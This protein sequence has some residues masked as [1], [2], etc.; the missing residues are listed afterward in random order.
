MAE[1][2]KTSGEK[3]QLSKA[4][5]VV[6]ELAPTAHVTAL[7][8]RAK[9]SSDLRRSA[10]KG[11]TI[12]LLKDSTDLGQDGIDILPMDED[13]ELY[14]AI[15]ESKRYA[16]KEESQRQ[17]LIASAH[18]SKQ[19]SK[20]HLPTIYRDYTASTK[21]MGTKSG[22]NLPLSPSVC[23]TTDRKNSIQ[24]V[25]LTDKDKEQKELKVAYTAP[26]PQTVTMATGIPIKRKLNSIVDDHECDPE[27]IPETQW[28]TG[29]DD[30]R[31]YTEGVG[32]K[33]GCVPR[34]TGAIKN[35]CLDVGEK[36][37]EKK[38]EQWVNTNMGIQEGKGKNKSKRQ[39]KENDSDQDFQDVS[40]PKRRMKAVANQKER[41]P[42][43]MDETKFSDESTKWMKGEDSKTTN[44]QESSPVNEE[45]IFERKYPA[46]IG[47]Q[48]F[49]QYST[50]E[51]IL[52]HLSALDGTSEWNK[53]PY[54]EG[55]GLTEDS[56]NMLAPTNIW[57]INANDYYSMNVSSYSHQLDPP[58]STTDRSQSV[59]CLDGYHA[60]LT[61]TP[62]DDEIEHSENQSLLPLGNSS[63]ILYN[64]PT[65]S[66]GNEVREVSRNR[67]DE[68]GKNNK[69]DSIKH[70][71]KQPGLVVGC[72][73]SEREELQ[74]GEKEKGTAM[75][76]SQSEGQV[77]ND[78]VGLVEDHYNECVDKEGSVAVERNKLEFRY[79]IGDDNRAKDGVKIDTHI[80]LDQHTAPTDT[81]IEIDSK[82]I[83]GRYQRLNELELRSGPDLN[84]TEKH[85][86]KAGYVH[87][88]KDNNEKE[89]EKEL[90]YRARDSRDNYVIS[91]E[92][93][94]KSSLATKLKWVDRFNSLDK[95]DKTEI[96]VKDHPRH[97]YNPNG[98]SIN[99]SP[100]DDLCFT[101]SEGEEKAQ[102]GPGKKS[103]F[104]HPKDP[105]S[106][107]LPTAN[108]RRV[109][110]NLNEKY[111]THNN[112][113]PKGPELDNNIDNPLDSIEMTDVR[114]NG[115]EIN[116]SDKLVEC[117][118][119]KKSV[120][121]EVLDQHESHCYGPVIESDE[122]II[123]TPLTIRPPVY[124]EPKTLIHATRNL[125]MEKT[126]E[127]SRSRLT[128][129]QK[130]RQLW[131]TQQPYHNALLNPGPRSVSHQ[132][133]DNNYQPCNDTYFD[134]QVLS[135]PKNFRPAS[136]DKNSLIDFKGQFA[137]NASL[138]TQAL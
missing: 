46:P 15:E 123:E 27:F 113:P 26:R 93:T 38:I 58:L 99:V 68:I 133:C 103:T 63:T 117:T 60:T 57:Y 94:L 28:S 37:K 42:P 44:E 97:H 122:D 35:I 96:I 88:Y 52:E 110:I 106:L 118:I 138:S 127:P 1:R 112:H 105:P 40:L 33:A 10:R 134:Q 53:K 136:A 25:V 131:N 39:S 91:G 80:G 107:S 30:K 31:R 78:R 4:P 95:T 79:N 32:R 98:K 73:G 50:I 48:D 7:L 81:Q 71:Q 66:C 8:H 12:G 104:I 24:R 19:T 114:T 6:V 100:P 76:Q 45:L 126:Q 13:E 115:I 11:Y 125:K 5:V 51:A 20:P 9:E 92:S 89:I 121:I 119:C 132:P 23:I 87:G 54:P 86:H 22:A 74:E 128:S 36:E 14:R 69:R 56:V 34:K 130:P 65:D 59:N 43:S 49:S 90:K 18:Y 47:T 75:V 111:G 3:K 137:N 135:P 2:K 84:G 77:D 16:E 109:A 29:I 101:Q 108:S 82:D 55:E 85:K 21:V 129:E 72:D 70:K 67:K 102:F 61:Q 120:Q 83:V 116:I 17:M 124:S 64:K 41:N 62:M